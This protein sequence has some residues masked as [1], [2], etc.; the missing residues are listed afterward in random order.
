MGWDELNL[1][2]TTTTFI[3]SF[4]LVMTLPWLMRKK[5]FNIIT[6]IIIVV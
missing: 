6:L 4:F 1:T 3:H 5:Y 2:T